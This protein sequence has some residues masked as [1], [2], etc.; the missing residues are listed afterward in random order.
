MENEVFDNWNNEKK[1]IHN[2]S[3]DNVFI[4]QREIWF[5]KM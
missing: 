4:N 2:Y 3:Y 1:E 5:I